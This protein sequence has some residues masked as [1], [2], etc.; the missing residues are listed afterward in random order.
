MAEGMAELAKM[1][2]ALGDRV[3]QAIVKVSRRGWRVRLV[4]EDLFKKYKPI[5]RQWA[6]E[7]R[8]LR[9]KRRAA[10][11]LGKVDGDRLAQ[12]PTTGRP[13]T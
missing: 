8:A 4:T 2:E 7:A 3:S 6:K 9:R 5:F 11:S 13:Q 10:A 1:R 12:P